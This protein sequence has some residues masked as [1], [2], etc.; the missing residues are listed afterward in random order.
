MKCAPVASYMKFKI[1]L[2]EIYNVFIY[3]ILKVPF[4]F[5]KYTLMLS[6]ITCRKFYF[7]LGIGTHVYI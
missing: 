2:Y 6:Y 3:E 1:F 7:H 5:T 4:S